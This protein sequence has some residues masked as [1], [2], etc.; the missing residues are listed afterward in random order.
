MTGEITRFTD[1]R[2]L[3]DHEI[4]EDDIWFSD[5]VIL[6][7]EKEFFVNKHVPQKSVSLDGAIVAPGF[8]DIQINGGFG[9]DFTYDLMNKPEGLSKVAKGILTHGVTSFC[10]TI[11]TSKAEVYHKVLPLLEAKVG[12]LHGAEV[13]GAHLEGPFISPEKKGAH[14]IDDI[15]DLTDGVETLKSVYKHTDNIRIV[16]L[17]PERRN[18]L[19]VIQWL[20]RESEICVSLGHSMA[21]INV[22]VEAIKK[23][24]KLITH[25]FNAMPPFHH[26]DPG[27]V[28]LLGLGT[29]TPVYYGIIADGIHT[30]EAALRAAYKSHPKGVILVTDAIS[31][32]GLEDGTHHIGKKTININN[33]SAYIA[34]TTTLCGSVATMNE[35]VRYFRNAVG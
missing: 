17:A 28:G 5:G 18:S 10:P 13:L 3:R 23:G 15:Q 7:P 9:I 22:A 21:D 30:H 2:V 11:V 35:S 25:L 4:Y 20:T 8:I 27:L 26:R 14:C 6:D 29:K 16:T 1:C 24:A 33:K 32:M 34:G 19:E 31:A 12:G